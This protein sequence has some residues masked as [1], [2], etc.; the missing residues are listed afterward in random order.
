MQET[1]LKDNN[2]D[3]DNN[4]KRE[5]TK[6]RRGSNSHSTEEESVGN[7][8]D[9]RLHSNNTA[10]SASDHNHRGRNVIDQVMIG[11]IVPR[12]TRSGFVSILFI[13]GFS[14]TALTFTFWIFL[15][16]ASVKRPHHS[17]VEEQSAEDA[18][19]SSSNVSLPK[20]MV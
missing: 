14:L 3:D 16:S 8:Q 15:L 9:A 4:S 5:W 1:R 19:P 12:R 7:E 18:S 10:S 11:A 2:D 17:W 20:K 13:F 6:K